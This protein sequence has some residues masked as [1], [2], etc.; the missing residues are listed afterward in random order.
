L[1]ASGY[2]E[3]RAIGDDGDASTVLLIYIAL[4]TSD[5]MVKETFNRE[6]PINSFFMNIHTSASDIPTS[7]HSY[8]QNSTFV[9]NRFFGLAL[10]LCC[11]SL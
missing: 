1:E 2:L 5:F 7:A 9:C 3:E 10:A 8:P 11:F 4:S 6:M